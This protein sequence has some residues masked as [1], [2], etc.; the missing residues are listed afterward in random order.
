MNFINA[1]NYLRDYKLFYE[2][3]KPKKSSMFFGILCLAGAVVTGIMAVIKAGEGFGTVYLFGFVT[4]FLVVGVAIELYSANMHKYY[5][6][7]IIKKIED[8]INN[9]NYATKRIVVKRISVDQMVRM[10]SRKDRNSL[11]NQY[12]PLF[13][14]AKDTPTKEVYRFNGIQ[15]EDY[16]LDYDAELEISYLVNSK[17]I[18]GVTV[19]E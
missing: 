15:N 3:M 13:V 7:S 9:S 2:A 12:I 4:V 17:L 16:P 18:S 6:K 10:V 14:E 8:D 19:I 5:A 1:N 11:G